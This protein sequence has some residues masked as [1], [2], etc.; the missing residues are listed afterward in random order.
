MLWS[1]A[2]LGFNVDDAV[3]GMVHALTVRFLW[4][5]DAAEEEQRPNAQAAANVL[6]L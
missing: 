2:T 3:P 1:S 6:W 4:L 5:I